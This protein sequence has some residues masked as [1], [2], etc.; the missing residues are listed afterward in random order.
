[1]GALRCTGLLPTA[2]RS[3]A[4]SARAHTHTHTC[5]HTLPVAISCAPRPDAR[6]VVMRKQEIVDALVRAGADA[7]SS[8]Q[9]VGQTPL[10][11]ATRTPPIPCPSACGLMCP[12]ACLAPRHWA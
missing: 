4:A 8:C 9:Y 3:V 12:C 1:M 6:D 10:Y 11:M 7:N 2:I 5:T